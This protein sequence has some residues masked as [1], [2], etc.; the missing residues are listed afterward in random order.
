MEKV[1]ADPGQDANLKSPHSSVLPAC[2]PMYP[3]MN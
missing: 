3:T 2:M 1:C